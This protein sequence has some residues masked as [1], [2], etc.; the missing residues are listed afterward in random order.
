VALTWLSLLALA[1]SDKGTITDS[2]N[3]PSS[4]EPS[5]NEPSGN[6]APG[7]ATAAA[8]SGPAAGPPSSAGAP[9]AT[10]TA[11]GAAP[12][13][14]KDVKLSLT[15]VASLDQPLALAQRA[16]SD[17]LFIAERVG[18]VRRIQRTITGTPGAGPVS[19]TMRLHTKPVL[20]LSQQVGI[21]GEGGLLGITFSPDGSRFYAHYTDKAG[22]TTVSEYPVSGS[23]A[24]PVIDGT[25]GRVLLTVDQPFSNHNGGGLLFGPDK[26][27]YITLG[28]GG[29]GG[30]P[31]KTGQ[32]ATDLLGSILRIDPTPAEAAPY[33]IP[34]D[35]PFAVSAG[36]ERPEVWLYGTRN[37]WRVSFDQATGDLWVADVGQEKIEEIDWLPAA[38]GW[39]RGANLGWNL[40]EGNQ[41]Y[42][43]GK[44]PANHVPPVASYR[45]EKNR[46]SITGG[47]VYRGATI[48]GFDGVYLYADYCTGEIFGLRAKADGTNETATLS[49]PSGAKNVVAFG[50]DRAGEV[51][52]LEQE[53]RISRINPS[54]GGA[55]IDV[56]SDAG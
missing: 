30:D 52:V 54:I 17:D 39:G 40:M 36:S 14:L 26:M 53:G 6:E 11:G 50:Q 37:P 9:G 25:Q 31:F 34:N 49:F 45:H 35:N 47:Y 22:D 19:E 42:G 32:N 38:S 43:S 48:A 15:L 5:S 46:C 21:E 28:D 33:T 1:C 56:T 51:Y 10:A 13:P 20:D 12:V 23:A 2:S 55:A 4:N 8:G 3:N 18:R 7:S 27:L 29:S 16:G 44:A 41:P 24:S